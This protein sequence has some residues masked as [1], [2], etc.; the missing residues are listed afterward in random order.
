MMAKE[1]SKRANLVALLSGAV[2]GAIMWS[3]RDVAKGVMSLKKSGNPGWAKISDEPEVYLTASTE[4]GQ[5]ALFDYLGQ[6]TAW[7]LV[8]HIADG[9]FWINECEEIL[10]LSQ[11]LIM[12]G[13]YWTWSASRKFADP[14]PCHKETTDAE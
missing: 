7:R 4:E 14:R 10:L 13:K 6:T 5:Q 12:M 9:F 2:A 1:G 3:K 8:D 11:S